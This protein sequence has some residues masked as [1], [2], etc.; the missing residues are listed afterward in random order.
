M[1]SA[2]KLCVT[3]YNLGQSQARHSRVPAHYHALM[4]VAKLR[5]MSERGRP[6]GAVSAVEP[7]LTPPAVCRLTPLAA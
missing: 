5:P 4:R 6:C 7:T 1:T 3:S 2:L